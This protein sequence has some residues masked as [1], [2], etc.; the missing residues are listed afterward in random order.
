M[1]FTPVP[2]AITLAPAATTMSSAFTATAAVLIPPGV[3]G[4]SV[5]PQIDQPNGPNFLTI[6]YLLPRPLRVDDVAEFYLID[7][8]SSVAIL[9]KTYTLT[10]YDIF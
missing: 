4:S 8:S 7:P 5:A 1:I 6:R 10:D 2:T 3:P 9:V